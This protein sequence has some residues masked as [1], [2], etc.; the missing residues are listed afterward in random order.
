MDLILIGFSPPPCLQDAKTQN[1]AKR[2]TFL[3]SVAHALQR[4]LARSSKFAE[5]LSIGATLNIL[6]RGAVAQSV[7]RPSKFPGHGAT[8]LTEVRTPAAA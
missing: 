6:G 2:S 7:E 4:K 5:P 3:N 1:Y 8:R